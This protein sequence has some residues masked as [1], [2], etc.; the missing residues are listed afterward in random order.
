MVDYRCNTGNT[1]SSSRSISA[2]LLLGKPGCGLQLGSKTH[3]VEHGAL[4]PGEAN[5]ES[6]GEC[7]E[8]A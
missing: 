5:Y 2:G 6:G 3:A 7:L 8:H 4:E 1:S